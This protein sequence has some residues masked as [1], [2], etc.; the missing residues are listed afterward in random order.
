MTNSSNDNDSPPLEKLSIDNPS[1]FQFHAAYLAYSEI[2]DDA[3]DD[4]T[5]K[6]LNHNITAL[7]Q[8]KIDYPTFYKNINE[9]RNRN[10]RRHYQK[11]RIKTQRKR[12]WRRKA[13]RR[14]RNKRHGN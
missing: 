11:A 9:H 13:Q 3:A 1:D 2:Y 7:Q 4:E 12:D 14:Q 6:D 5:K 10:P 8:E